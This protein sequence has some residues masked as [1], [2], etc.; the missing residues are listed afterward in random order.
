MEVS[1]PGRHGNSKDM[2]FFKLIG[3]G[4]FNVAIFS[5]LLLLPA[6]TL[7][8]WRAWV[9]LEVVFVGTVA[10]TVSVFRVNK[11]LLEASGRKTPNGD[12]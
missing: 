8:W 10:S 1:Q 3:V 6:G 4:V 7:K 11:D 5:S 2:S 9:F 12:R